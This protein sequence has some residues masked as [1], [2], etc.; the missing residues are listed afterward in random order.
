M[1]GRGLLDSK[2][3]NDV[4]IFNSNGDLCNHELPPHK[5]PASYEQIVIHKG[6]K[7]FALG[8]K[9]VILGSATGRRC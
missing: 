6:R 1:N 7:I 8:G 3:K 2:L 9:P 5:K 4:F